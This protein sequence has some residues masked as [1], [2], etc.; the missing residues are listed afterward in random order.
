MGI[1]A[2]SPT[3]THP[4]T[5]PN[6]RLRLA[7]VSLGLHEV[8]CGCCLSRLMASS[9]SAMTSCTY[10]QRKRRSSIVTLASVNDVLPS[11]DTPGAVLPH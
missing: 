6:H 4:P 5:H 11:A 1:C 10:M 8:L 7:A 9:R 2:Y 3:C